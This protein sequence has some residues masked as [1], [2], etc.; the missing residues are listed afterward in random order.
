MIMR[1]PLAALASP[2]VERLLHTVHAVGKDVLAV[3]AADVD[4]QARFPREAL[5][6]MR[7]ARL[8]SAY[9]PPEYGGLGLDVVQ[10]AQV[11]EALGRYCGSSAMIYAMHQ[12][13]VACVVHHG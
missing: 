9:V 11:C 1:N 6:A 13:Q 10:V 7:Q 4:R 5:E 12:I 3:H 2:D 8:L